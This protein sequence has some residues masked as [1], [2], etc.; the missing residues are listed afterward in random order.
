MFL[1]KQKCDSFR[2][3]IIKTYIHNFRS[4]PFSL[5]K[6]KE[7]KSYYNTRTKPNTLSLTKII[8]KILCIPINLD[9]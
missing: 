1:L 8:F 7:N 3:T 4:D 2:F 5:E 6:W 9:G